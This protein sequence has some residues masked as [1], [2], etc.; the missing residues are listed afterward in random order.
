[1]EPLVDNGPIPGDKVTVLSLSRHRKPTYVLEPQRESFDL[2]LKAVWEY[3]ELL[4]FLIW[5]D[6][7]VRYK[8][9]VIGVSWVILQPLLTTVVFT[10]VFGRLADIPSDGVPY[11]LLVFTALLPWN[12][13]ANAIGRGGMSV[14]GSANLVSK[15][16]FPRLVLPL[17]SVLSPLVDFVV[18]FGVLIGMAFWY[19]LVP[20]WPVLALP[21]FVLLTLLSALAIV[22]WLAS[23]NVRYRDVGHAIPFIVQ[24]WFFVSP[25]VYPVTEI[26]PAWRFVYGLNPMAGVIEGFRWALLGKTHPDFRVIAVSSMVVVIL[27]IPALLYFRRTERTFADIV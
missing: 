4:Y 26:D 13:F 21:L 10:F 15:I 1:M 27:L 7:K 24:L 2:G 20:G 12:L 23:L 18:G 16:Y 25:V 5:R 19:R 6:V 14:V 17:S 8:Q 9:T 3:R 11:P 22:L